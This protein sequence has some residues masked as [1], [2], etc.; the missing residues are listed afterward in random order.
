MKLKNVNASENLRLKFKK[1]KNNL[2]CNF[3]MTLLLLLKLVSNIAFD[4][5]CFVDILVETRRKFP[6][7]GAYAYEF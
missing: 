4:S 7:K 1:Q 2:R 3:P 6:L 5:F